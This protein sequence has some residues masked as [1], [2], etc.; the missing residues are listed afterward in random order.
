M[1]TGDKAPYV[2]TRARDNGRGRGRE[3]RG[4]QQGTM[5]MASNVNEPCVGTNCVS[6]R[7]VSCTVSVL[8]DRLFRTGPGGIRGVDGTG[9][10]GCFAAAVGASAR[11]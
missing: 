11:R 1:H 8:V 9:M 6:P 2:S 4:A 5:T 3:P 7:W 10:C